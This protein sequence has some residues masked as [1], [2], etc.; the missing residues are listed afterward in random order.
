[1][2][3][4]S[5]G[6]LWGEVRGEGGREIN[7]TVFARQISL[8][9]PAG[10]WFSRSHYQRVGRWPCH[11]G[12]ALETL[13][14]FTQR[15]AY[16]ATFLFAET[17]SHLETGQPYRNDIALSYRIRSLP[18]RRG[19]KNSIRRR[20]LRDN[21]FLL[22][23]WR[24]KLATQLLGEQDSDHEEDVARKALGGLTCRL[25]FKFFL[26]VVAVIL[27]FALSAKSNSK[28]RPTQNSNVLSNQRVRL[29]LCTREA[30]QFLCL[31]AVK[32][33]NW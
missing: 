20:R 2:K 19:V 10:W 18:S 28:F 24:R 26:F 21:F 14:K 29:Q 27:W 5:L 12:E 32:C 13:F 7:E 25:E 30:S 31:S 6:P 11:P 17:T 22:F 9:E 8:H 3:F 4:F 15:E 23:D 33:C 16:G 1:M